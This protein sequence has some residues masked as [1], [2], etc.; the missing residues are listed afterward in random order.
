[1]IYFRYIEFMLTIKVLLTFVLIY[2]CSS[3]DICLYP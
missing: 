3:Q 1:M 2:M